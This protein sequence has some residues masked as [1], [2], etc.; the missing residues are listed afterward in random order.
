MRTML[1]VLGVLVVLLALVTAGGY[2]YLRRSLP[3][4]E[5][6]IEFERGQT[7]G[8]APTYFHTAGL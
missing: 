2:H 7:R 6:E 1:K 3:Q 4:V 8:P 5:G